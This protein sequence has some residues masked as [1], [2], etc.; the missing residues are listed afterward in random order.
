MT[1][2][3]IDMPGTWLC[4][5]ANLISERVLIFEF[6]SQEISDSEGCLIEILLF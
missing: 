1:R 6:F 4:P 5:W 3:G 2:A